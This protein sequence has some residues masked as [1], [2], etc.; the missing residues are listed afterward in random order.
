VLHL[1]HPPPHS[2]IKR[3]HEFIDVIITNPC[4][5]KTITLPKHN[6]NKTAFDNQVEH[7]HKNNFVS[8][9]LYLLY[10]FSMMK[11]PNKINT[12]NDY[13]TIE[14][15]TLHRHLLTIKQNTHIRVM[16]LFQIVHATLFF[17]NSVNCVTYL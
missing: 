8:F 2:S 6:P 16:K 13:F 14:N 12:K 9:N 1:R 15:V 10:D 4:R 3:K 11:S 17:E 7:D 5:Y